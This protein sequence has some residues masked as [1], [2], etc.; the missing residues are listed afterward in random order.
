MGIP[1][2][3]YTRV[4]KQGPNLRDFFGGNTFGI[5]TDRLEYFPGS[6]VH[7][8]IVPEESRSSVRHHYSVEIRLRSVV[9][10]N[11]RVVKRVFPIDI[12]TARWGEIR[13]ILDWI[14]QEKHTHEQILYSVSQ[15]KNRDQ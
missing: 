3:A 10:G 4:S 2:K 7:L 9:A 11:D 5:I 14:E 12:E 8:M 6:S 15:S 1:W 13:S